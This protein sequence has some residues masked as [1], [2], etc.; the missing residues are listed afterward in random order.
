MDR[1]FVVVV[2]GN[3]HVFASRAGARRFVAREL[4]MYREIGMA[5]QTLARGRR[6][7]CANGGDILDITL[8]ITLDDAWVER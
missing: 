1:V 5:L 8:D 6:W 3:P 4:R 2:N 7:I